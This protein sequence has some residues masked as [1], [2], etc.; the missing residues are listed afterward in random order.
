LQVDRGRFV[1][2]TSRS[3][4]ISVSAVVRARRTGGDSIPRLHL[5]FIDQQ[6]PLE[7]IA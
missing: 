7:G 5:E 2:L 6:F 4:G 3:F 1:R